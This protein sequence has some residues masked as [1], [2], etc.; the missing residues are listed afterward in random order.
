M[1]TTSLVS[2]LLAVAPSL[3]V[4]QAPSPPA[5]LA[6]VVEWV[7]Q[8]AVPLKTP[9]A[10]NGFED[11]EPLRSI[12]GK[13]RI[14]ALGEAT[15]GTREFFQL[16][17]RMLEFLVERMDFSV[18]AIESS[19]AECVAVNDYVEHGRGDIAAALNGQ[20]FWTWD[21]EEVLALIEWMRAYN[22]DP[23]RG[24]TLRFYGVDMQS[25]APA[26]A[27]ALAY[28]RGIDAG[29]ADALAADLEP[30]GRP[31]IFA[32]YPDLSGAE[33]EAIGFALEG[34]LDFMDGERDMLVD[35]TSE[36]EWSLARQH[37]VNAQQAN[38][39]MARGGAGTFREECMAANVAWMLEHEPADT[40]V[41]VWAHNAHVNKGELPG[42]SGMM[43]Y[44]LDRAF[45]DEHVAFGMSFHHGGFQ[46]MAQPRPADDP[47]P[48]L[49][50][51]EL[52][53]PSAG[54]IGSVLAQSGHALFA[55]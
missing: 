52:E 51:F 33:R 34:M 5:D 48:A 10:G 11:M 14:V 47:L 4:A 24:R 9:E 27:G 28:I 16:K 49:R 41:V 18:F 29:L 25:S 50:Q 53:P 20:G 42:A 40:R 13:A 30:L 1:L 44:H 46:A 26:V 54:A 55:L 12:I 38:Q 19:F 3:Q 21:T 32:D 23:E 7:Q 36:R 37:G 22:A 17:H 8:H 6:P 31:T 2:C 43:G 39:H 35:A 15:H 45:G